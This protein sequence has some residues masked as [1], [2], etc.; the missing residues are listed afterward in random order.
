MLKVIVKKPGLEPVVREVTNEL[1]TFQKIVEGHIEC[2]HFYNDIICIC[3]EEGKLRHLAPNF[4]V[5]NDV[6][7]GNVIFCLDE[8][9]E[10]KSLTEDKIELVERLV[11]VLS[12]DLY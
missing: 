7:V 3:N 2:F 8:D 9:G 4:I 12:I 10:F 5:N 6:I 1:K 11:R